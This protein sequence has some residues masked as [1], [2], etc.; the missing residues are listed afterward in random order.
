[1]IR[2]GDS[3]KI[4]FTTEGDVVRLQRPGLRIQQLVGKDTEALPKGLAGRQPFEAVAVVRAATRERVAASIV[5]YAHVP[6][7][8]MQQAVRHLT[9]DDRPTA[10]PCPY[11]DVTER[12]ETLRGT[13]APFTEPPSPPTGTRSPASVSSTASLVANCMPEPSAHLCF[14]RRSTSAPWAAPNGSQVTESR[15]RGAEIYPVGVPAV[16]A[17]R[18]DALRAKTDRDVDTARTGFTRLGRR[19]SDRRGR[20]R[21]RRRRRGRTVCRRAGGARR[22]RGWLWS[23]RGRG[24]CWSL[25]R[26]R[27]RRR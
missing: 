27:R 7:L 10:D 5:R 1:M 23:R 12:L 25:R 9:A 2:S 22:G 26:R 19:R 24:G 14:A 4:T 11:G 6:E 21:R 3:V 8:R 15:G 18:P 20:P 13:E 16:A 17:P